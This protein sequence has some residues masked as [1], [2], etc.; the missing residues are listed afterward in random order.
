MPSGL[1]NL[2]LVVLDDVGV[3]KFAAYGATQDTA[4]TPHFDALAAEGLLFLRAYAAPV[5]GPA[6]AALHTG[7]HAFRTGFGTNI[8]GTDAAPAYRLPLREVSLPEMLNHGRPGTYAC[9][10]FGKWHLTFHV[11]DDLHPNEVGYSHFAGC[12]SNT[13]GVGN[14]SGHFDWRRVVDG[15]SSFVTGPPFD[16][17]QWQASVTLADAQQWIAQQSGPWFAYVGLN[18]PHAPFSVPP[19]EFLS[20]ATQQALSDVGLAPGDT[21]LAGDPKRRRIRA[22]HAAIEATDAVLG[23]LIA[24][25]R[26]TETLV[27]VIGDNGT[28]GDIILPPFQPQHAKRTVYEQGVHVPM[29]ALGAGVTTPAEPTGAL[30]HA[31][32]VFRTLGEA[33]G[34]Q[35]DPSWPRSDSVS[36]LGL[37]ADPTSTPPRSDVYCENFRPNGADVP[38]FFQRALIGPRYKLHRYAAREEFYDLRVD[39]LEL[40]DRITAGLTNEEEL[41]LLDMRARMDLLLSS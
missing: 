25:V 26:L 36:F 10:A 29:L 27:I 20:P 24:S 16:R 31:V 5:C 28:P 11:G 14:G 19:F 17:T 40:T 30:V 39:P 8:M 13:S 1:P 38:S 7:R 32:D 21:V 6:R 34:A 4:P 35:F 22:Y 2:L 18:P 3:E 12:M 41:V 23:E 15:V 9:G 33:A 37:L